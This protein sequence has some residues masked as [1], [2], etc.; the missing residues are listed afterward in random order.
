MD[1]ASNE[2]QTYQQPPTCQVSPY[3][4][5]DPPTDES[6]IEGQDITASV[7]AKLNNIGE[8]VEAIWLK[9]AEIYG[10]VAPKISNEV[11]PGSLWKP[12]LI[13]EYRHPIA[14]DD[15]CMFQTPFDNCYHIRAKTEMAINFPSKFISDTDYLFVTVVWT[16]IESRH[17]P[18][19]LP[20]PKSTRCI[21]DRAVF[22]A[23]LHNKTTQVRERQLY[24]C[25]SDIKA[26]M[27]YI[28]SPRGFDSLLLNFNITP[29]LVEAT[30]A[31]KQPVCGWSVV[32]T[33]RISNRPIYQEFDTHVY[34]SPKSIR[35]LARS[36]K[37]G[38][39]RKKRLLNQSETEYRA[40]EKAQAA[41]TKHAKYFL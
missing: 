15:P 5:D 10:Q 29:T 28:P 14:L 27:L 13:S 4:Q 37:E 25:E 38:A 16:R 24:F 11:A 33:G 31:Q 26:P 12:F 39:Q 8:F 7:V 9:S 32:I 20:D 41:H 30:I 1:Q 35:F 23:A 17:I 18:V 21:Q 6:N 40:F 2:Q 22:A 19:L 36:H 3:V 34:E